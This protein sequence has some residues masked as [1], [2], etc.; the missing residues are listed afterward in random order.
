[1]TYTNATKMHMLGVPEVCLEKYGA[2][3][4]EVA[5]AMVEGA[6]KHSS[7]DIA[8]SVTGL[9]GP[10]GGSKN[11]PVGTVWISWMIKGQLANA[12]CH[13]FSGNRKAVREAAVEAALAGIIKLI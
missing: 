9:A 11:L 2:V 6:L 12:V 8:V 5:L 1:M 7:A 13:Q 3:S 10:G 4:Q